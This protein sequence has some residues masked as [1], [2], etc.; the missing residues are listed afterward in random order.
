MDKYLL[1]LPL[2]LYLR[3]FNKD[4]KFQKSNYKLR[5]SFFRSCLID[6]APSIEI[7]FYLKFNIN[8]H[9]LNDFEIMI[10]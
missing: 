4:I 1:L 3:V 6:N 8:N 2:S 9:N 5:S 10:N 7:L